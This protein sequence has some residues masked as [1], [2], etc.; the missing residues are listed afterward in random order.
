MK[1]SVRFCEVA[2]KAFTGMIPTKMIHAIANNRK[3]S[4]RFEIMRIMLE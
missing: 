3:Q 4:N 2:G 1:T